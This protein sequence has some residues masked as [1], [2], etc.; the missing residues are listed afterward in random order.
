MND[1]RCPDMVKNFIR[2][3]TPIVND[4]LEEREEEPVQ[5]RHGR[6]YYLSDIPLEDALEQYLGALEGAG[7]L[8]H[9][10]SEIVALNCER[11]GYGRTC[12]GKDF[13]TTLRFGGYGRN[14]GSSLGHRRRN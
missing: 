9:T 7:A 10:Q 4:F 11:A 13:L 6:R 12:L 8:E 5:C 2:A 14:C 1:D 3:I